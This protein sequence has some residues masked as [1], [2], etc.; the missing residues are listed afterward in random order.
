MKQISIL[1]AV[2]FLLSSTLAFAAPPP[3]AG[4][5]GGPNGGGDEPLP[6]TP[7]IIV[8]PGHGGTAPGTTQCL[9]LTEAD[10]NLDI[11]L[12]LEAILEATNT[13]DVRLTR[14]DNSTLS[15]NDRYTFANDQGGHAL[16]SIH[17]NGSTDHGV[18]GTQGFYGKKNKDE[19]F[20]RVIHEVLANDPEFNLGV[21]DRGVTNFPSG[22]LL[23]SKMPSTIQEA[24][25]LSNTTECQLMTNGT[26]GRQQQIAQALAT[27]VRDWFGK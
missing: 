13:Y 12:R 4:T 5:P 18:N 8:D 22:V 11:A 19:A 1:F 9:G 25:F 15:N 21:S 14:T 27:G 2:L 7:I 24:V 10:A 3:W 17:L 20:T 16:V 23:K 26:G 6:E